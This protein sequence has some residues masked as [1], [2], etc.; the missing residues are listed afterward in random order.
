MAPHAL[1]V[2]AD[3]VDWVRD[4]VYLGLPLVEEEAMK[5][6]Q[7]SVGL[8]Y[9]LKNGSIVPASILPGPLMS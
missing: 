3:S 4:G 1:A 9:A 7:V 2:P 5:G 6:V 8:V